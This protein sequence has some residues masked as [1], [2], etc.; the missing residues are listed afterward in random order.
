MLTDKIIKA[1]HEDIPSKLD[2]SDIVNDL[3]TGGTDKALS[4]EQGKTIASIKSEVDSMK[5]SIVNNKPIII[6]DD[7][8]IG[9]FMWFT[10]SSAPDGWLLCNG[11]SLNK[12]EYSDLF[13][14]IGY[15]FGGSGDTF[16]VP[17]LVTKQ[18]FIRSVSATGKVGDRQDDMYISHNHALH[19]TLAKKVWFSGANAD[20]SSPGNDTILYSGTYHE[21][22][23]PAGVSGTGSP[24]DKLTMTNTAK[25]GGEETRPKNIAFAPYIKAKQ[26]AKDMTTVAQ[27]WTSFKENGGEIGG[28]ITFKK[29]TIYSDRGGAG[30][31]FITAN[32]DVSLVLQTKNTEKNRIGD[33]ALV[34]SSNEFCIRPTSATGGGKV[35]IGGANIPFKDI[36]LSGVSKG[37]NGY[38]R[39]PNGLIL[40]WGIVDITV[41]TDTRFVG[42]VVTFPIA[43]P[44][45]A[46]IVN[47]AT[48]CKNVTNNNASFL[49][50]MCA[51]FENYN[52]GTGGYI[53]LRDVAQKMDKPYTIRASW[54][55]I[56]Y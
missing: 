16:N 33:L 3:M 5:E 27:E 22:K 37:V 21:G 38:T 39:L 8:P 19:N 47:L 48:P 56:G 32:D 13:N 26:R 12:T 51:S 54:V 43:F 35:D 14:V 49:D 10:S 30:G 52:N 11:Q 24:A 44:N 55:A 7:Y 4:A 46:T 2:K 1:I 15:A 9:G 50:G 31:F 45:G 25:E 18:D 34:N 42:K 23:I 6:T 36:Y 17:D 40:Q 28:D 29:G 20:W 41:P 53:T